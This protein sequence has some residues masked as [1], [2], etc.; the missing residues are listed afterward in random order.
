MENSHRRVYQVINN[1]ENLYTLPESDLQNILSENS[2]V[3]KSLYAFPCLSKKGGGWFENIYV[4]PHT[5]THM[6]VNTY[7]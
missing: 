3:E 6:H 7:T 4:H 5:Y 2:K 1:E